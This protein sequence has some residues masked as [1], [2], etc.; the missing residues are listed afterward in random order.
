MTAWADIAW[1]LTLVAMGAWLPPALLGPFL[2]QGFA[3][4]R[5]E[6]RQRARRLLLIAALP[7]LLPLVV[8]CAAAGIA[9]AKASGWIDDHCIGHGPGHPH[10][11][12][13]HLPTLALSPLAWWPQFMFTAVVCGQ[14][15]RAAIPELRSASEITALRAL[16]TRRGCLR[17]VPAARSLAVAHGLLRPGMLVTRGVLDTLSVHER[18][19]LIAHEAAHLRHGDPRRSLLLLALSAVHLPNGRRALRQAWRPALEHA[20]DDAAS[21][22]FGAE[23][24]ATTL[25]RVA[26]SGRTN[27]SMLPAVAGTDPV[28]RAWRLLGAGPAETAGT[29]VFET[30]CGL[31]LLFCAI[32]VAVAHH[33]LETLLGVI[34][35]L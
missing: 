24:V 33:T 18:R 15:A 11:C 19:I 5:I 35:G 26:R 14:L 27:S 23:D 7:V 21:R 4:D 13:V 34:V 10:L 3:N 16:S 2:V 30:G 8:V 9:A 31:T 29:P 1:L 25:A 20:A 6:P 17:V 32:C 12:F 28:Q 22:R